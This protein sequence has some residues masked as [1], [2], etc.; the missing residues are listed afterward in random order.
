MLAITKAHP[1]DK[2]G[3]LVQPAE[4]KPGKHGMEE[5]ERKMDSTVSSRKP[6]IEL[7]QEAINSDQNVYPRVVDTMT[8][9]ATYR[10][11]ESMRRIIITMISSS[12]QRSR[13]RSHI[14]RTTNSRRTRCKKHIKVPLT[15]AGIGLWRRTRLDSSSV[16]RRP[17]STMSHF[18][19]RRSWNTDRAP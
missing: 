3:K 14:S 2:Q 7:D 16:G 19:I 5:W 12:K 8:P 9:Q 6:L 4:S 15:L 18:T 1:Q 17:K 11:Q 10:S 13:S